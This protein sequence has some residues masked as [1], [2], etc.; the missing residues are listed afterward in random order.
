VLTAGVV[1]SAAALLAANHCWLLTVFGLV[2]SQ[3]GKVHDSY[4]LQNS[5]ADR[6]SCFRGSAEEGGSSQR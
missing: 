2:C 3:D 6:R 5:R 1:H 4:V